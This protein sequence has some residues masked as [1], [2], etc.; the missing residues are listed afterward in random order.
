M[1]YAPL[2]KGRVR[3][4]RAV[5]PPRSAAREIFLF[6]LFQ[7]II[8]RSF[9]H[10]LSS[11][12]KRHLYC[13]VTRCRAF[14]VYGV[15][16]FPALFNKKI[17]LFAGVPLVYGDV[18]SYQQEMIPVALPLLSSK[19]HAVVLSGRFSRRPVGRG[20]V[21]SVYGLIIVYTCYIFKPHDAQIY[22]KHIV[23]YVYSIYIYLML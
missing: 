9:R 22:S 11:K 4:S 20:L 8:H 19:S 12:I 16:S 6:F 3:V 2:A 10:L 17:S 23:Y 14:T 18:R 13:S 7:T 21:A 1:I 15:C 5:A